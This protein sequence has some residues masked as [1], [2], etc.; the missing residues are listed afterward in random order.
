MALA[1]AEAVAVPRMAAEANRTAAADLPTE[2][3]EN[4]MEEADLP[5][6]A[7]ANR[8]AAEANRTAAEAI[9]TAAVVPRTEAVKEVKN[10]SN[11]QSVETVQPDATGDSRSAH[12]SRDFA[13]RNHS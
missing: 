11:E 1:T 5:M 6:A 3:A 8:T 10:R 2:V 4:R 12:H 7:V 13:F 9:R